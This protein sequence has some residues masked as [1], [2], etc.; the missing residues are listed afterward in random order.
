MSLGLQRQ[1][2]S[3]LNLFGVSPGHN[4]M[5]WVLV[6]KGGMGVMGFCDI[7]AGGRAGGRGGGAR[8]RRERGRGGDS[9]AMEKSFPHNATVFTT[10]GL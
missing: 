1:M 3:R 5:L 8:G 6:R 9:H 10:V 2:R 4:S 7:R